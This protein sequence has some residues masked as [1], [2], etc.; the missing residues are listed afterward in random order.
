[1]VK[2]KENTRLDLFAITSGRDI[3][4]FETMKYLTPGRNKRRSD[5]QC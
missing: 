2:T 1:M 4:A 5:R 3:I